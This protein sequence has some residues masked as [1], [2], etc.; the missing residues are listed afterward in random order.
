MTAL[1]RTAAH[2]AALLCAASLACSSPTAGPADL[3][4]RWEGVLGDPAGGELLL[5][6]ATF[7]VVQHGDRVVGTFGEAPGGTEPVLVGAVDGDTL[8]FT[9]EYASGCTIQVAGSG[10]VERRSDRDRLDVTFRGTS[11]CVGA[12]EGTG[13][14]DRLRC[15]ASMSACLAAFAED[16]T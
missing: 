11:T 2:A 14:L 1:Q 16:L 13:L 9:L 6:P 8:S 15:P 10:T 3:T 5:A 12:I 7:F 4:G